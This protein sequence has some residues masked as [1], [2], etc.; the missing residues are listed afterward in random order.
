MPR[1]VP[2]KGHYRADGTYVDPHMRHIDGI[3]NPESA[4]GGRGSAHRTSHRT[5][6]R[7]LATVI[8]P[9]T[10]YPSRDWKSPSGKVLARGRMGWQAMNELHIEKDDGTFI[11]LSIDELNEDDAK[12]LAA[13]RRNPRV[14]KTEQIP[15]ENI[16]SGEPDNEAEAEA[17][18]EAVAEAEV[19]AE[20][21]A[22]AAQ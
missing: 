2:V 16:E 15:S 22:V 5:T 18:T 1:D 7:G 13:A 9:K 17:Q 11:D 4:G 14:M 21:E 10:R 19:D 8:K 20:A 12:W 3:K 6:A